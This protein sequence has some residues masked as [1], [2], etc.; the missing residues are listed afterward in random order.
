[1]F[2]VRRALALVLA[3]LV[4]MWLPVRQPVP[5]REIAHSPTDGRAQTERPSHATDFGPQM[6]AATAGSS[7][8]R[9]GHDAL[10]S[11]VSFQGTPDYSLSASVPSSRLR[12]HISP[13]VRAFPLLI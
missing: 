8:A 5:E 7:Q 2:L 3:L 12:I 1:M 9:P 11:E 10:H 13:P 4:T 6:T